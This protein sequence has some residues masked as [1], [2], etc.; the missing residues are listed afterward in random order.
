LQIL[1][2]ELELNPL[3]GRRVL[4]LSGGERRMVAI[5][6]ALAATP[7][8]LVLD[9]PTTGLDPAARARLVRILAK[10]A[11]EVPSLLVA[12]QDPG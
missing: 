8:L 4:T 9:E 10:L 3:R 12:E 7:V 11:D 2:D 5:A 1:L 6:A